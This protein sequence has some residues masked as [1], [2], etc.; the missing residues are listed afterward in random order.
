MANGKSFLKIMTK[1]FWFGN[2]A[3]CGRSKD[4]FGVVRF[5]PNTDNPTWKVLP[6]S[7][8]HFVRLLLKSSSNCGHPSM[9]RPSMAKWCLIVWSIQK[10][11]SSSCGS[12]G[13]L[14]HRCCCTS[15]CVG[16]VFN[17]PAVPGDENAINKKLFVC[18]MTWKQTCTPQ[19]LSV[20]SCCPDWIN[21]LPQGLTLLLPYITLLKTVNSCFDWYFARCI[22]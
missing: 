22:V 5:G 19:T 21:Q 6:N 16:M 3:Q 8:F 20:S 2:V 7:T 4:I 10:G 1:V 18:L 15:F 9:G 13:R 12:A 11:P 14:L 17:S